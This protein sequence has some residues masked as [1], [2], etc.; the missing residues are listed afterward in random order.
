MLRRRPARRLKA[1]AAGPTPL[2]PH[3]AQLVRHNLAVAAHVSRA[4]PEWPDPDPTGTTTEASEPSEPD[5]D[6]PR[7]LGGVGVGGGGAQN[8]SDD[9]PPVPNDYF[10][11]GTPV[12]RPPEGLTRL[13]KL[14]WLMGQLKMMK[15]RVREAVLVALRNETAAELK[16]WNEGNPSPDPSVEEA[17][18][19]AWA[20]AS[21]AVEHAKADA[22]AVD[23]AIEDTKRKIAAAEQ[24]LAEQAAEAGVDGA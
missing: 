9:A 20:E 16:Y 15:L 14:R 18:L 17:L 19:Y 24:A 11:D 4:W 21:V 3:A 8:A 10:E 6:V 22:K 5:E 7:G 23:D 2:P 13:E 1:G 12:P